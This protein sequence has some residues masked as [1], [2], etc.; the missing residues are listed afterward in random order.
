MG[1]KNSNSNNGTTENHLN[2]EG[3][4]KLVFKESVRLVLS[5]CLS[6]LRCVAFFSIIRNG[7]EEDEEMQTESIKVYFI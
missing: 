5:V 2:F 7:I 4:S 6:A 1:E 3:R